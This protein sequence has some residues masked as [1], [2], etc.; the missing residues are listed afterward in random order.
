MIDRVKGSTMKALFAKIAALVYPPTKAKLHRLLHVTG[1]AATVGASVAIWV[2][3]RHWA[4]GTQIEA[5]IALVLAF[6]TN[7]K[8]IT[9][10]L[11][12]GVDKLPIPDG[13]AIVGEPPHMIPVQVLVD[14][15]KEP[16]PP[17][18]DIVGVVR[19]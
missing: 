13:M 6:L 5:Q 15:A 10:T 17:S 7:V 8:K 19:K 3:G 14:P 11:D 16:A 2:M 18:A 12:A 1:V 4:L 9:V